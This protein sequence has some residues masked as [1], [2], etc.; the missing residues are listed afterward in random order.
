VVGASPSPAVKMA[1]LSSVVRPRVPQV[2]LLPAVFGASRGVGVKA[3][4]EA[5][6]GDACGHRFLLGGIVM[7]LHVL[8]H[9]E[10]RGKPLIRLAGLDSGDITVSSPP[11]RRC[12]GRWW[13]PRR[14]AMESRLAAALSESFRGTM[15]TVGGASLSISTGWFSPAAHSPTL[16]RLRVCGCVGCAI[17]GRVGYRS[18]KPCSVAFVLC[19]LLGVVPAFLAF[20]L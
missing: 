10:R 9:H 4:L 2:V 13:S 17:L 11:W 6:D 12:L 1:L 15:Y 20:L 8:P 19:S 16:R 3:L 14:G 18:F 7:A 5:D